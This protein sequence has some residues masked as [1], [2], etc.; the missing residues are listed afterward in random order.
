[1]SQFQTFDAPWR[2]AS[3]ST[4]LLAPGL[5]IAVKEMDGKIIQ[6]T[7]N[8]SGIEAGSPAMDDESYQCRLKSMQSK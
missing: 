2:G 4:H 1:M 3:P 6:N 5:S 7:C 8:I